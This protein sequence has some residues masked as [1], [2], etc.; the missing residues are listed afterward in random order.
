[1]GGVAQAS[2]DSTVGHGLAGFTLY[3]G[4]AKLLGA[5]NQTA[6]TVGY[7]GAVLGMFPD[8]AGAYGNI[9]RRDDWETYRKFHNFDYYQTRY[10]PLPIAI[11]IEVDKVYHRNGGGWNW[12]R[13]PVFVVILVAEAVLTYL[14]WQWTAD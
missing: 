6:R 1:M 13:W 3:A 4:T 7:V 12:D 2:A 10:V 5:D 8:I 11:H 14:V 9:V